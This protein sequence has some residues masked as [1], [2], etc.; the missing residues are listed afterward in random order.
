MSKYKTRE[1][2]LRAAVP[3]INELIFG[4]KFEIVDYQIC[5]GWCKSS[6]AMGETALPPQGEDVGLDDFYPPTIQIGI[7]IKE[8]GN[9]VAVL[10]HEMIHAF[11]N[12]K[13]HG[14]AFRVYAGPAGF[15]APFTKFN[16]SDYLLDLCE[17]ICIQLGEWPGQAV[18]QHK[19]PKEKK[20]HRG[21]MF[22]PSCGFECKTTAKMI[23]QF[24]LPTCPCGTK[25]GE[26]LEEITDEND[27]PED[28]IKE[29]TE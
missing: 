25:M 2:W 18:I 13:G 3:L 15:E 19:K 26:D 4:S 8:P 6:K 5:C 27:I 21:K 14:K 17:D 10:A 29:F 16:P 11:G 12:I 7:D 28:I 23:D 24:G 22:C 1:E 20:P 9:I